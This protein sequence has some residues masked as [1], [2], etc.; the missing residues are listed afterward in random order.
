MGADK[1]IDYTREDFTL[2]R[3]AY[4][5]VFDTVGTTSFLRCKGAMKQTGVY[6]AA[7]TGPAEIGQML[8]TSMVGDKKVVGGVSSARGEDLR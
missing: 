2:A 5:I 7:V 3:D 4:D 8:W 6:L 1:V